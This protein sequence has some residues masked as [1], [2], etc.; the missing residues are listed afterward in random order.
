MEQLLLEG[1]PL[2]IGSGTVSQ[3]P[4]DGGTTVSE[5]TAEAHES[6]WLRTVRTAEPSA[7][8]ERYL[9]QLG[10]AGY[11]TVSERTVG[12][13]RF[14]TLQGNGGT[15]RVSTRVQKGELR[16]LFDC[17]RILPSELSSSAEKGD[18]AAIYMYGLNMD[19][20]GYNYR[21]APAY[22]TSGFLNCGMLF[23]IR[24]SDG[25]LIV[26]DGGASVQMAGG[27]ACSLDRFLH[28]ITGKREDEKIRIAAWFVSHTHQD[29]L[30]GF[31][32]FLKERTDRYE[33]ERLI[34][35]LPDL[36]GRETEGCLETLCELSALLAERYPSC[37]EYK[38]HTGDEIT[39][40]DVRLEVLYTHEDA[41]NAESG[42]FESEN[43][44]DTTTVLRATV[45]KM[46]VLLL[47]DV[48]SVAERVLCETVPS[49]MLSSDIV[50]VAH[51]GFYPIDTAYT[52]ADAK[53]ACFPQTEAGCVK[54]DVMIENTDKVK[55]YARHLYYSG[56]VTKTVGFALRGKRICEVYRYD[57]EIKA[58]PLCRLKRIKKSSSVDPV[59]RTM[60]K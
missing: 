29:H 7:D 20:G 12:E 14:A 44:N 16:V 5:I 25:S 10:E 57:R 32:D 56:D 19:P 37:L 2:Y 6:A 17:N 4:Y 36:T 26:I 9:A 24:A 22:N 59:T 13:N 45:G 3:T 23:V 55:R 18:G 11:L 53:I 31:F 46:R 51:H 42:V 15:V 41:A 21:L 60:T 1:L 33:L 52:Y 58:K 40:G 30:A 27:A 38:P 28:S 48:D 43:F 54:N 34:V 49:G 47:G 8:Y 39:L 35:N 50:Q